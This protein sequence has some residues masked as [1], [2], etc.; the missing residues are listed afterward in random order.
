MT[1][2]AVTPWGRSPTSSKRIDSGTVMGVQPAW[3]RFAY[4]VAPTP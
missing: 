3:I 4:S 1:S 2:L